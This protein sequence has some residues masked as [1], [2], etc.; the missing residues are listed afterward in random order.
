[1]AEIKKFILQLK[2]E[3]TF[4]F[5]VTRKNNDRSLYFMLK[6]KVGACGID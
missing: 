3:P 1:M 6:C 2:L 5:N 4:E